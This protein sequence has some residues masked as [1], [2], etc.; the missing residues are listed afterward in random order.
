MSPYKQLGKPGRFD[1]RHAVIAEARRVRDTLTIYRSQE[2]I[3][4]L[5]RC[6][7]ELMLSIEDLPPEAPF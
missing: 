4:A 1:R 5:T 3:D 6:I 7:N 2:I